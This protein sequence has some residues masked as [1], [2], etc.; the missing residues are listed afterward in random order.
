MPNAGKIVRVRLRSKGQLNALL[1]RNIVI[2]ALIILFSLAVGM[3]GY[4][5]YCPVSWAEAFV[6][7]SMILTGMGPVD[8]PESDAGKVFTGLYAI[9]SGVIFLSLA[10]I[11]LAPALHRLMNG[12]HVPLDEEEEN[13]KKQATQLRKKPQG[14]KE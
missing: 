7:A 1:Y 8:N 6:D 14:S 9:Y 10:A 4:K 12:L 13:N 11:V 3:V 5:Y 2:A